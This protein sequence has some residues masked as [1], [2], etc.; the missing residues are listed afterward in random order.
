MVVE[1]TGY[2]I[3]PHRVLIPGDGWLRSGSKYMTTGLLP[4]EFRKQSLG[5]AIQALRQLPH[6]ELHTSREGCPGSSLACLVTCESRPDPQKDAVYSGSGTREEP[7]C[8]ESRLAADD[9]CG[10]WR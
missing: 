7:H 5:L 8:L 4:T 2:E 9:V 1:V 10:L 3:C 6:S